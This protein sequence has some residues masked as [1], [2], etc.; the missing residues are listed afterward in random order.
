MANLD[1]KDGGRGRR[2]PNRKKKEEMVEGA[3]NSPTIS[4]VAKPVRELG[5]RAWSG[6]RNNIF[7]LLALALCHALAIFYF[8]PLYDIVAVHS[9]FWVSHVVILFAL[10]LPREKVANSSVQKLSGASTAMILALLVTN[11]VYIAYQTV[12]NDLK[13]EDARIAQPQGPGIPRWPDLNEENEK[14]VS[15]FWKKY[16]TPDEKPE[17]MIEIARRESNFNQFEVDG[18]TPLRGRE[19]SQDVCLM[20]INEGWWLKQSTNL[21]HN[22]YTLQGCLDMALWI[23]K[24]H[25]EDEWNTSQEARNFNRQK[26]ITIVAPADDWSEWVFLR[27]MKLT[28]DKDENSVIEFQTPEGGGKYDNHVKGT[29]IR[30]KS[31]TRNSEGAYVEARVRYKLTPVP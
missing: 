13:N 8:R 19:N 17:N 25:G 29:A 12:W 5:T 21:G 31:K 10:A 26:E 2:T 15:E 22:I 30:F 28:W 20:Q 6:M 7:A 27:G 14:V 23:R 1:L 4:K 16:L 24:N 11:I 9:I 3:N 18:K